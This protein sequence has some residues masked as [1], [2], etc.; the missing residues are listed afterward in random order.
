LSK[1]RFWASLSSIVI[2]KACPPSSIP[3]MIL[4]SFFREKR[5]EI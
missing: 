5:E 3:P 4:V 2:L 1:P